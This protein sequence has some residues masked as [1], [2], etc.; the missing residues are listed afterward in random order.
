MTM[1][2]CIIDSTN[3]KHSYFPSQL[4]YTPTRQT[5]RVVCNEHRHFQPISLSSQN[6][7]Y[8]DPRNF[9]LPDNQMASWGIPRPLHIYSSLI[10]L[11]KFLHMCRS[12]KLPNNTAL[13]GKSEIHCTI[14]LQAV[15]SVFTR[16]D[17]LLCS[18]D[19]KSCKL[20]LYLYSFPVEWM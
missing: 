13:C 2:L 20:V 19:G 6:S 18:K 15:V 9:L 4:V 8:Q 7:V 10:G 3:W 16:V 17:V 1:G 5:P 12:E 14:S 11:C